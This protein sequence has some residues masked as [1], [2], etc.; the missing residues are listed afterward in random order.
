MSPFK[1]KKKVFWKV[2]PKFFK[3]IPR[4]GMKKPGEKREER[5]SDEVYIVENARESR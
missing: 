2:F 4:I 1:A 3:E 5:C